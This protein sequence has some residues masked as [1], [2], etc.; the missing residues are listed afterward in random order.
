MKHFISFFKSRK[1]ILLLS[2]INAIIL[3]LATYLWD[4]FPYS[5]PDGPSTRQWIEG[6]R[7]ATNT[8]ESYTDS[9]LIINNAYDRELVDITDSDG[10]PIGNIDI[11]DRRK[12]LSFL[13]QA[14][15]AN[16]YKYII[17]DINFKEG[18]NTPV[19]SALFHTIASMERIVIP[20]HEGQQ[21]ADSVLYDKAYYNDYNTTIL[22]SGFIKYEYLKNGEYSLPLSIYHELTNNSID[23]H[24]IIY[25]SGNNFC[26]KCIQISFPIRAWDYRDINGNNNYYHLGSDL[27]DNPNVDISQYIKNKYIVIGNITE[28]DIHSTF[29]G[30]LPGA[31][32]S[33][34]ALIALINNEHLIDWSSIILIFIFYIFL[35]FIIFRQLKIGFRVINI[36]KPI[37]YKASDLSKPIIHNKITRLFKPIYSVVAKIF[38]P[39]CHIVTDLIKFAIPYVGIGILLKSIAII[40]YFTHNAE[41]NIFI[42][43][44]WLG[45]INLILTYIRQKQSCKN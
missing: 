25:Y 22:E 45:T 23:N 40:C 44:F 4:N 19:D 1:K 32:I 34:N 10:F 14:K 35:S 16:N 36:I 30:P 7:S 13:E 11:T 2:V 21:L 33:L 29:I 17:L 39:I 12:L 37:Y 41:F 20:K 31:I 18:Y 15:R 43:T 5:F 9:I 28:S 42:P 24:G 3:L 6:F 26:R 38:A 27:I 8:D